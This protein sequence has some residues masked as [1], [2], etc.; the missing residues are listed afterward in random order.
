MGKLKI[1]QKKLKQFQ[2][3]FIQRGKK[4]TPK[5]KITWK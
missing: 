5:K 3:G 4:A 1:N 2:G